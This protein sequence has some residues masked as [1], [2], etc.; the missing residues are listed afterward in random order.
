MKWVYKGIGTITKAPGSSQPCDGWAGRFQDRI[1][2]DSEFFR[3]SHFRFVENVF[4][5]GEAGKGKPI[6]GEAQTS[7]TGESSLAG[8]PYSLWIK[9]S[10]LSPPATLTQH[11]TPKH[12]Q[13]LGTTQ[14]M[15]TRNQMEIDWKSGRA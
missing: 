1:Q 5:T 10:M 14:S 9:T 8:P 12:V 6:D 13:M 3:Q 11:Q 15:V 2:P 4:Q 7:P